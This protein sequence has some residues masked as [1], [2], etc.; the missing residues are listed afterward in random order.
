LDARSDRRLSGRRVALTGGGGFIGSRL[1]PLLLAHGARLTL[2]GPIAN[3]RATTRS[4]VENQ[5]VDYRAEALSGDQAGLRRALAGCDAVVHLAYRPHGRNTFWPGLREEIATNLVQTAGLL[6]A[7][8]SAGVTQFNL[9]SSVSVYTPPGRGVDESGPVGGAVSAYAV[10]KLAQEQ[11]VKAWAGP[12]RSASVLRLATVY[13]PG[14]TAHRAIPIFL[15]AAIS[16]LPLVLHG[17]GD[18]EFDPVF[19]DDVAGA[20]LEALARRADG[21][22]N[23][24]CGEGWTARA[25][26]QL[27]VKLWGEGLEVVENPAVHARGSAVCDVSLAASELGFRAQTTLEAGLADEIRW[28]RE[29]EPA[30]LATPVARV[31]TPTTG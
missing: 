17:Q 6:E 21:T 18:Q 4:L 16:G 15:T 20:F 3:Q 31:A 28:R 30:T 27:V 2:L 29:Q 1:A 19:V 8:D 24:G 26:A 11:M 9:A 5:D 12:G 13:G 25:V 23:I 7:A 22:F 14:E 10:V